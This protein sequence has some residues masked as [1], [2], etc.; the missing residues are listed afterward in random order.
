[1]E[2]NNFYSSQQELDLQTG[3]NAYV[4]KIFGTMFLGLLITAFSAV[5]TATSETMFNLLYGSSFVFILIIAELVLV[6]VLSARI[7]KISHAAALAMYYIYAVI[8]GITL[9]SIFFV[10]DM[11]TV[12]TAFFTA[13]ISF[14]VM[15]VYGIT[16]KKDLTKIGSML[17]MLLVGI[18]IASLINI[19]IGSESFEL[20]ISFVAVAVFVGLVAFDTQKLKSYYYS[21]VG[22]PQLQRK[23][24]IIGALSLYL[25]FI[26]IFLYL[27]RIF[28]NKRN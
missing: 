15:A 2:N 17:I 24:G 6:M 26:N 13:A 27:L 8:N 18:V 10:Y 7:T 14:G 22:D 25:D 5:F 12:Y 9:S 19:F 28:G 3:L 4:S 16:T 21:S 11:G 20:I 1:M 23:I